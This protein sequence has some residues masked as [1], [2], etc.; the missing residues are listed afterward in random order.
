M[1]K[2]GGAHKPLTGKFCPRFNDGIQQ[3][4]CNR[5]EESTTEHYFQGMK[6]QTVF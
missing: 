6:K 3:S 5:G 2:I 1:F 4:T